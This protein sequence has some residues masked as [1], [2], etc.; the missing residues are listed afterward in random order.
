MTL[1]DYQTLTDNLVRDD[2]GKLTPT[3]RDRAI[4][5]AVIRYS[6][7]RPRTKV[8]DIA[9]PGGNYL[10]LPV[11]WD[12]GFSNLD[13]LEYPLGKMPPE[14]LESG[15]WGMYN[16]P[17]GWQVMVLQTL[18]AG[19]AVRSTYTIRHVLDANTDTLPE[20]DREAVASY[21][22]ALLLDQLASLYSGDSDST[23]S[24]DSVQHQSKAS[25]F[26]ARARVLRKRYFDDLGIDTKR[27]AAAGAVVNLDLASSLGRDRLTHPRRFR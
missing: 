7:D 24:A 6:K 18:P 15:S 8:E 9:A 17:G 16:A 12:E 26:A 20:T 10:P 21:A 14:H 5:A 2:A 3:E 23:I 25:E 11:G 27:N 1:T 4:A 13:S 22:A 19:A